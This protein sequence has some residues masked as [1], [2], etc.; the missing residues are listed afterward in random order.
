MTEAPP[1]HTWFVCKQATDDDRKLLAKAMA[2]LGVT[3][4]P[5]TPSLRAVDDAITWVVLALL[6]LQALL[7]SLGT[8]AGEDAWARLHNAVAAVAARRSATAQRPQT[9]AP[10][11][12]LVLQDPATGIRILL[13]P[14]LPES[15]Y[16]ALRELEMG[17]FRHG[18]L[19]YDREARRWRSIADEAA[20]YG[21]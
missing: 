3:A 4:A 10:S 7:T 18:P 19:H 1:L 12:P 16:V 5:Q 14:D 11:G 9:G 6:P 20:E 21:V 13:E 8:K 17:R 15:A 2:G